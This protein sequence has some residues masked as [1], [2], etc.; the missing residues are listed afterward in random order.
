MSAL[1]ALLRLELHPHLRVLQRSPL[2]LPVSGF[3]AIYG[4]VSKNGFIGNIIVFIFM[5][6]PLKKA[7]CNGYSFTIAPAAGG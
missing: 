1:A 6:L 2:V 4:L 3:S 7:Y 5:D